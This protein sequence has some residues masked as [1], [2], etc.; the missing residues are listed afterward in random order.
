MNRKTVRSF[1]LL[2]SAI[3]GMYSL[4]A[5]LAARRVVVRGRSMLP[6][7]EPGERVLFDR[8]AYVLAPPRAGDIVIARHPARPGVRIIK[9]I[10]EKITGDEYWLL[11]ENADESTDSRVLGTFQRQNI[12]ARAWVVFWPPERFCVIDRRHRHVRRV[13]PSS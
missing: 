12:V 9:R 3:P 13:E 6:V 4:L 11:G 7:L 8:L 1:V 2:A 10:A 5:F